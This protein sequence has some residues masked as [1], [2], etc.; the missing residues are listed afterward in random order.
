MRSTSA[1]QSDLIGAAEP[2]SIEAVLVGQIAAGRALLMTFHVTQ[3]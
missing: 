3:R 1:P 2:M